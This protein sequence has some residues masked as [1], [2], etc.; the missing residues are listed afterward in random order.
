MRVSILADGNED[1]LLDLYRWLGADA[2]AD[3]SLRA[4]E[5]VSGR[6][7]VFDVIDIV[8]KDATAAASLAVA[9]AAFRRGRPKTGPFV[10]EKDGVR[11]TISGGDPETIAQI[12]KVLAEPS[13]P[14]QD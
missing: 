4:S 7:G 9:Y 3:L 6:M 13:A 10:L 1:E 8:L 2:A 12:T 5:E 14:D 11:V